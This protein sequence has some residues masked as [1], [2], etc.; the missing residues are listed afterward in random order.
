VHIKTPPYHPA[1]NGAAENAV[2]TFK[3]SIKILLNSGIPMREAIPKFLFYYRSTPQCTTGQSPAELHI[4]RQLKTK[5]S[6]LKPNTRMRVED[7]LDQQS[8][9]SKGKRN[10]KFMEGDKVM[11]RNHLKQHWEVG[12][13]LKV[14]SPVTYQVE[15]NGL[16]K[17]KHL[18]QLIAFANQEH[19]K[20]DWQPISKPEVE[21]CKVTIEEPHG[22]GVG[23]EEELVVSEKGSSAINEQCTTDSVSEQVEPAVAIRRSNR[24]KKPRQIFD[25]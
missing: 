11:V 20:E 2:K 8:K 22:L 7:K 12:T 6:L 18:D 10:F 5:L 24:V 19:V 14:L 21:P 23:S 3:R 9:H 25:L 16:I 13:V 4:G 1:S 17:K 15:V